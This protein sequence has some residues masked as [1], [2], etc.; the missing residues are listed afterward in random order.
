MPLHCL[1]EEFQCRLSVAGVR[2]EDFKNFAFVVDGAPEIVPFTVDLHE[3]PLGYESIPCRAVPP[4]GC[5]R[6]WLDRIPSTRRF[7]T[8]QTNSGPNLRHRNRTI[9]W[10]MSISGSCSRSSTLRSDNGN[11]MFII[12]ARRMISGEVLKYRKGLRSFMP[13]CWLA[14]V[15]D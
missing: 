13:E 12:T 15:T 2:H 14:A 8:S 9:S 7:R 11:R 1:L 5:Q 3:D 4:S 10:L 6:Q